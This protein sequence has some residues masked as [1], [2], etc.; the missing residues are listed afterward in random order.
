MRELLLRND[1][2][3]A[4]CL[5]TVGEA[6]NYPPLEKNLKSLMKAKTL[7]EA[8]ATEVRAGEKCA[9]MRLMP[10]PSLSTAPAS[11]VGLH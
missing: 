9:H 3:M 1:N 10:L 7:P 6:L 11:S 5:L 4:V 8:S 2:G